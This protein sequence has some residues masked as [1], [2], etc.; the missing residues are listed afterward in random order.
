M[1][2]QVLLM[3]HKMSVEAWTGFWIFLRSLLS[4]ELKDVKA[5]GMTDEKHFCLPLWLSTH[6][7][8]L[9]SW[10]QSLV[11]LMFFCSVD[12]PVSLLVPAYLSVKS[13]TMQAFPSEEVD[14]DKWHIMVEYYWDVLSRPSV[15]RPQ[16]KFNKT[17]HTWSTQPLRA[18][19]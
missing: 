15:W 12:I 2:K 5:A 8:L 9:T 6:I 17:E 10:L 4:A 3:L 16:E 7:Y 14:G 13:D 1:V 18:A 11:I 19:Q